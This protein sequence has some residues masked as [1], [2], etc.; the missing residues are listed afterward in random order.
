[1]GTLTAHKSFERALFV[2]TVCLIHSVCLFLHKFVISIL[3]SN[4]HSNLENILQL[5]FLP[6]ECVYFGYQNFC[7]N[8]DQLSRVT[9]RCIQLPTIIYGSYNHQKC[10]A[11][12]QKWKG[13]Q[14]HTNWEL[15]IFRVDIKRCYWCQVTD[16]CLVNVSTIYCACKHVLLDISYAYV[17]SSLLFLF[18]SWAESFSPE[19]KN[20]VDTIH[21]QY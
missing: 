10:S 13:Q 19:N 12:F 21:I 3:W 9:M 11:G 14:C 5:L 16:Q 4:T 2:L 17:F 15:V 20:M 18:L 1:M 6:N 8:C 7:T